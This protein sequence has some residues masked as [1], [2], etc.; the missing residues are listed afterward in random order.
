MCNILT[1]STIDKNILIVLQKE[2][3]IVDFIKVEEENKQAELLVITVEKMLAK[4][5]INYSNLDCISVINGPGSFIGLKVALSFVKAL[6]SVL[7]NIKVIEN[8]VFEILSFEEKFDFVILKADINGFYICDKQSDIN[9]INKEQLLNIQINNTNIITNVKE[10]N[11]FIK[12]EN[13]I[14]IKDI[15][16]KNLVNINYYKYKIKKFSDD[17][18]AVYIREPQINRRK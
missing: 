2:A 11:N 4:N 8:N 12:G 1:I 5:N 7:Y 6:K 10:L 17:I 9:Y 16:I 3:N 18:K 14:L 13:S 15:D